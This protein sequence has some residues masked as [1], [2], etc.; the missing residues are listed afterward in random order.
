MANRRQFSIAVLAGFSALAGIQ[1]SRGAEK[2][3]EEQAHRALD[4]WLDAL[5]TG[6]P[7]VVETVLAP[8]YQ[9]LRS[10]G[11]GHDKAGYLRA[12]PKHMTRPQFGDIVATGD[13]NVMVIRY[14]IETDQSVEGKAIVGISP[15]LSVFRLEKDRWL[16]SAHANF[17]PLS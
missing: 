7:E 17:A 15:R 6:K 13:S 12:L 9:I 16:I 10:D 4:P 8:E 3:S 11:S 1:P 14:R 5:I 2:L